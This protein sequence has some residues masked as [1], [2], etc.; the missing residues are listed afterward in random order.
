MDA[1]FLATS[2]HVLLCH[3]GNVDNHKRLFRLYR[4]EKVCRRSGR[5][6]AIGTR[7]PMLVFLLRMDA[8]SWTSSPIS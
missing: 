7:A 5:N 8:V 1:G 6:W 3:E 2:L 4:E